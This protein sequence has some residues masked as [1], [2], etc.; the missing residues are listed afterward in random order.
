MNER[1]ISIARRRSVAHL[2]EFVG[3]KS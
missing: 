3:P 1:N 2:D